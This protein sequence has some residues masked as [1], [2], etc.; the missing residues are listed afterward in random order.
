MSAD[1][2]AGKTIVTLEG[3]PKEERDLWA[4]LDVERDRARYDARRT[5]RREEALAGLSPEWT[6]SR[7]N[8]GTRERV[9]AP[10][11]TRFRA[12]QKVRHPVFGEGIVV[13]SAARAE[14]EEVTVAFPNKGVKR[15]MAAFAQLEPR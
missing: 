10:S 3:L 11:T 9:A 1:K 14:D 7:G 4:E 13:S 12:G 15:L 2:C 5:A 6:G 8:G